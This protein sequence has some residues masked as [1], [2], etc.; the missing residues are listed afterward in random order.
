M[1]HHLR[2]SLIRAGS[3]GTSGAPEGV[4]KMNRGILAGLIMVAGAICQVA[5]GAATLH[6][7]G[8]YGTSCQTGGCP[9]YN[10]EV[11]NI[12]TPAPGDPYV[13]TMDIYQNQGGARAMDDPLL[14]IFGVANDATGTRLS[15]T[16]ISSAQLIDTKGASTGIGFTFAGYQGAMTGGDVYGFLSGT[17]LGQTYAGLSGM[18]NSNSF[19]NWSAWDLAIDNIDAKKF[20]IYV[21]ALS[22]QAS[23]VAFAGKDYIDLALNGIPEGTFAVAYGEATKGKKVTAYGT[24]F[25]EAGLVDQPL[26]LPVP[27]PG[28]LAIMGLGLVLLGGLGT[29]ASSRKRRPS[30]GARFG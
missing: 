7:G 29:L 6:M 8:G 14:L 24:P 1:H 2:Q 17:S 3:S 22:P 18:N 12:G 23:G 26:P 30:P 13:G 9:I 21:F 11:N 16:S 20:G 19:T 28:S 10:G 15:N 5:W 4:L 25:T 27:E